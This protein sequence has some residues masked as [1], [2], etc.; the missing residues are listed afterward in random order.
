MRSNQEFQNTSTF[1][2]QFSSNVFHSY[3]EHSS[4]QSPTNMFNEENLEEVPWDGDDPFAEDFIS[5]SPYSK[6]HVLGQNKILSSEPIDSRQRRFEFHDD[7][8]RSERVVDQLP[9][10]DRFA[11][12]ALVLQKKK[13]NQKSLKINN[14]PPPPES[15]PFS[16][17]HQGSLTFHDESHFVS[18][19]DQSVFSDMTESE[20]SIGASV[21]SRDLRR[22]AR[23]SKVGNASVKQ[24]LSRVKEEND[25]MK[26]GQNDGEK[27]LNFPSRIASLF[28]K[29]STTSLQKSS[30]PQKSSVTN[31]ERS[32]S[33][34][35]Q[36]NV[37]SASDR[38]RSFSPPRSYTSESTYSYI[39]WPGTMDKNGGTVSL[40]DSQSD[41]ESVKDERNIA[42][43][44]ARSIFESKDMVRNNVSSVTSKRQQISSQIT[45]GEGND[46]DDED[47]VDLDV[48]PVNQEEDLPKPADYHLAAAIATVK[49]S[50][51]VDTSLRTANTST[52]T[53]VSLQVDEFPIEKQNSSLA[54][55]NM[56][57]SYDELVTKIDTSAS[58]ARVRSSGR[59]ISQHLNTSIDS[60]EENMDNL[61]EDFD[62]GENEVRLSEDLLRENERHSG[63]FLNYAH[64]A[65][66]RGYRGFFDKTVDVPNL[67]DEESVT[68][69]STFATNRRKDLHDDESD[70][71][72]GLT[73]A[74]NHSFIHHGKPNP[75][76]ALTPEKNERKSMNE[77]DTNLKPVGVCD[78][79]KTK[80]IAIS[81][82]LSSIQSTPK[83]FEN[84]TTS[85]EFDADLTESDTDYGT[86]DVRYRKEKKTVNRVR[87][88][89]S[90]TV[91]M[92][93]VVESSD[94]SS[95]YSESDDS[96]LNSYL[97]QYSVDPSQIRKLVKAYRN[98]S[99]SCNTYDTAEEDSKKA[100]ALFEMRSRIMQTDLERGYERAGGTITVDD[101]VTTQYMKAACRVR[102]AVIVSKAW[103]DGASP[104]EV[105][106]AFNLTKP[107]TYYTERGS[108]RTN[109]LD[110]IGTSIKEKVAWIDD[111]EFSLIRCFGGRTLRGVDIF[112]LG[113]CQSMLLKLTHE[114][115]ENL[116]VKLA[117]AKSQLLRA[118][119][120]I[121]LE[122]IDES[123][124]FMS[125][126]EIQYLEAM[127]KVKNIQKQFNRAEHSFDM[128]KTRIEKLVQDM[129]NQL[130]DNS[131][132]SD[133]F[134]FE[135]ESHH[136]D[137]D[138]VDQ[139][140]Q[141][142]SRKVQRAELK[143]EVA[144][145]EAQLAKL[146]V[147]N[148]KKEAERLRIQ[149]EKELEELK[150][151]LEDMEAKSSVL[152][153]DFEAK[154]KNQTLLNESMKKKKSVS[155]AD[156]IIMP[157]DAKN[158]QALL[159][160]ASS[161]VGTDQDN[162]E[163]KAKIKAKFRERRQNKTSETNQESDKHTLSR[164]ATLERSLK[165]V[166]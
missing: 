44:A 12:A 58:E 144:E 148:T 107:F 57:K 115:C 96:K 62:S 99:E 138:V 135:N 14:P 116:K 61:L 114:H 26:K 64:G 123:Q 5:S 149:K 161:V 86:N 121:Q 97:E 162:S 63:S 33:V 84:R 92:P 6:S 134:E 108:K 164:I 54:T 31:V 53:D 127:E 140:H 109:S 77:R 122:K 88:R 51:D 159:Y 113:D 45:S 153:S 112:T 60:C 42:F 158:S 21:A 19:G 150:R 2:E 48:K 124:M 145:R 136:E 105:R 137:D 102:D 46:R 157:R 52:S 78:S 68:S 39:G 165:S 87:D 76:A 8:L 20:I 82:S 27:S 9:F 22:K 110:S 59:A 3:D 98:M 70:V 142:W 83:Q 28:G 103:K 25:S 55:S 131:V 67:L 94:E 133:P 24:P 132:S 166:E 69:A 128:V 13:Q 17:H 95:S 93:R 49:K 100:F 43:M 147:E 35:K 36:R 37:P 18:V 40:G 10:R 154:L 129:L 41:R 56:N 151:K 38:F 125:E 73:T 90:K 66:V 7:K 91:V 117:A 126:S 80:V 146:E 32:K 15:S 29:R 34:P 85:T 101:I 1:M 74:K 141:R 11:N 143:A 139:S 47:I 30:S 72:D 119:Q 16:Q 79:N 160:A 50:V 111:S 4:R 23:L 163:L 106:V 120:M 104:Q 118:E 156:G 89:F 130:D 75:R 65:N 71:F 152:L 81:K 155:F